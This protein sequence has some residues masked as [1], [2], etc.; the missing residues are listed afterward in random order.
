M[1]LLRRPSVMPST[2]IEITAPTGEKY[3]LAYGALSLSRELVK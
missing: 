2:E 3:R 1:R